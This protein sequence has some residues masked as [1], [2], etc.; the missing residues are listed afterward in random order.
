MAYLKIITA[1]LI[2]SSLGIFVRKTGLPTADIIFYPAVIAGML[3][4]LILSMTGRMRSALKS[5]SSANSVFLLALVPI[6]FLA[7]MYLFYFA[8]THTTIANAVLTHYTAPIFV[9]LI[10]P[11][12]LKEKILKTTWLAIILSSV[13]LWFI[14]G[15]PVSGGWSVPR[16]SEQEGIIAGVLSG[17]AYALIILIIRK[18]ALRYSSL[19]II[20]IQNGIVALLL[21]PF[22]LKMHLTLQSLPYLIT[23]G[24]V[25]S[26]IAPLLYVQGLKSVKANEAAILGYFEPVGAIILALIFLN[27]IPGIK[28][29]LGGALILYSGFMILKGVGEQK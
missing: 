17:M 5:D 25:H 13:G 20:F 1:I 12:F 8:F 28:A 23:L 29:L 10:A 11:F 18:I 6:C 7:N 16:G 3:Q 15:E 2:W 22:V 21:F 14:L 26:T 4:L 27:E 19:F 24:I 9:A